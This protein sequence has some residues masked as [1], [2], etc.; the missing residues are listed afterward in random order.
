MALSS[1]ARVDHVM[2]VQ[3]ARKALDTEVYDLILLDVE[4][5]DGNGIEFCSQL[6]PKYSNTPIIFSTSHDSLSEK[7]MGFSAGAADYI[8]KPFSPIELKARVES[9]IRKSKQQ[10]TT[11]N[12]M[13]WKELQIN[14]N[15]QEVLL[16]EGEAP[17][18]VELTNLEFKLLAYFAARPFEL[19]NRDKILDDIWGT[20]IHVYHRSVDTH[21][22]KLRKKLGKFS[23]LIESV[24][25][26][27]YKFV[28]TALN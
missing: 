4:L 19:V 7:V 2:S 15:R 9:R 5:P 27:G 24:H 21:V 16:F 1:V 14:L 12:V 11:A 18:R 25:G 13:K 28:P 8:S 10:S 6:G 3:E 22:S 26:S 20:N 23:H 17:K